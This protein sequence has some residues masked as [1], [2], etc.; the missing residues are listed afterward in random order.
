MTQTRPSCRCGVRSCRCGC[1]AHG[2]HCLA[3][4]EALHAERAE[5]GRLATLIGGAILESTLAPGELGTGPLSGHMLVACVRG[6]RLRAEQAESERDSLRE[7][8]ER[9]RHGHPNADK[10]LAEARDE[11]KRLRAKRDR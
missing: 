1:N 8:I 4:Q 10:V 9:L 7:E 3:D 11:V 5:K 6:L 2:G